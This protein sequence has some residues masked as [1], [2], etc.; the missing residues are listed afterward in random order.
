MLFLKIKWNLDRD[1][2]IGK[3]N[4]Q[5]LKRTHCL[6]KMQKKKKKVAQEKLSTTEKTM[7]INK[8]GR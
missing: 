6:K 4:S 3:W 1:T 7:H 8:R 2:L 5:V